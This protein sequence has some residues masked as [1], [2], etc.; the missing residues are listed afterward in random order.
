M[1]YDKFYESTQSRCIGSSFF[2]LQPYRNTLIFKNIDLALPD[3]EAFLLNIAKLLPES[4]VPA[5][6]MGSNFVPINGAAQIS[7]MVFSSRDRRF[8]NTVAL[9]LGVTLF[10]AFSAILTQSNLL[11]ISSIESAAKALSS[12]THQ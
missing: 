4:K 11:S 6:L 1:L 12:L 9:L 2:H 10:E 5:I 3:D 8:Q 7:Q